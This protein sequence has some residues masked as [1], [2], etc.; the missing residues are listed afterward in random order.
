MLA[1]GSVNYGIYAW[2]IVSYPLVLQYP[3]IGVAAGSIAGLA[4]NLLSSRFLLYRFSF[5]QNKT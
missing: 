3:I 5:D 1:G 4:V 2:L